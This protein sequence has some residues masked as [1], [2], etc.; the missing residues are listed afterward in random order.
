MSFGPEHRRRNFEQPRIP[1][2]GIDCRKSE[3]VAR[4]GTRS[5]P[6]DALNTRGKLRRLPLRQHIRDDRETPL[7]R[8][9]RCF[10]NDHRKR[11]YF[12]GGDAAC[13]AIALNGIS[14]MGYS[15]HSLQLKCHHSL[16]STVKPWASMAERSRSRRSRSSAV[17][18]A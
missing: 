4:A 13:D 17:P 8:G 5:L 1:C 6:P 3:Q 2:E 18:P 16:G 11:G 14:R 10:G 12:V 7:A 9:E 15:R